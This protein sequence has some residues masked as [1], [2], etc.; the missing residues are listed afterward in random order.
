MSATQNAGEAELRQRLDAFLAAARE[1]EITLK[2]FQTLE[3]E[4]MSSADLPTL[5]ERL[6]RNAPERFDCDV[7]SLEIFDPQFE[8]QRMLI[9]ISR[10]LESQVLEIIYHDNQHHFVA[11]Y[12]GLTIPVLGSYDPKRHG[13]CFRTTGVTAPASVALLP[14]MRGQEYLGS[15]N[16]GSRQ[17]DRFETGSATDFLQHIAA[18]IAL[19]LENACNREQLK[20]LGLIDPLTGINN[21]R[22]FDQRLPEEVARARRARTPLS[23]L[24]IDIDH[25]KRINDQ[26]GHLVGDE[27]LRTAALRIREQLR[28]ID[29][30]ARYGG[31]EFTVLLSNTPDKLAREVAERIRLRIAGAPVNL[32]DQATLSLTVSVGVGSLKNFPTDQAAG[33]LAAQ[34]VKQAD[35][36]LYN[37][38][39][40][41]RNRIA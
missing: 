31:E 10:T 3:L 36:A 21:R 1:N 22:Y 35:T 38:K 41:G 20:H 14:L 26:H 5:L 23:C 39:S 32:M 8:I 30:V 37:A 16:L 12:E 33:A 19:A 9:E 29:F 28:S 40:A 7:V 18:V 24:F 2:K 13:D 27:V 4:L 6:L 11:L 15:L 17:V 34:L 25:F